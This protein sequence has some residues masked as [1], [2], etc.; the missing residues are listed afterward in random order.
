MD[1]CGFE[2]SSIVSKF[3]RTHTNSNDL[4]N[5]DAWHEFEKN[6]PNAFLGMYQFWV[7]KI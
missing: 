1:F 7:Q 3:K 6:N 2:N 4:Y 5:L